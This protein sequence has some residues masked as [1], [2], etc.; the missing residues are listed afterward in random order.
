[1]FR[2]IFKL[3]L[4]VKHFP[5]VF[6]VCF[7]DTEFSTVLGQL[8]E[9]VS[10]GWACVQSSSARRKDSR[11][12][13]GSGGGGEGEERPSCGSAASTTIK[14]SGVRSGS[15]GGISSSVVGEAAWAMSWS[16]A[17][18]KLAGGFRA[19]ESCES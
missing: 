12:L 2:K 5:V 8:V 15:G 4:L 10:M 13:S 7:E 11:V 3:L 14:D 9:Y 18:A 6:G 17:G 1:M 19:K 16:S